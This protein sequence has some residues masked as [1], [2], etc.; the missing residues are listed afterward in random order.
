MSRFSLH[1]A[2]KSAFVLLALVS[3]A[4][5]LA[6]SQKS[7][8]RAADRFQVIKE[9]LAAEY[10][11]T[12][13]GLKTL[14]VVQEGAFRQPGTLTM[15]QVVVTKYAG[16]GPPAILPGSAPAKDCDG[17]PRQEGDAP[18]LRG[19]FEFRTLDGAVLGA[20]IETPGERQVYRMQRLMAT[21]RDWSDE[22]IIRALEQAGA[23][24]LP[25]RGSPVKDR[26][27][28]QVFEQFF[29]QLTVKSAKFTI[30]DPNAFNGADQ[31]YFDLE[32]DVELE[33]S[34]VGEPTREYW[35]RF[36]PFEGRLTAIHPRD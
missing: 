8:A 1:T 6:R 33:S 23:R 32:W 11:E 18:V 10:P 12:R 9:F 7:P 17:T 2:V 19:A 3:T 22:Q 24:F 27:R 21:H 16:C 4:S 36:E 34:R 13:D 31:P 25:P 15:L 35:A 28:L 5:V 20:S 14:T 29:G 26:S 30:R